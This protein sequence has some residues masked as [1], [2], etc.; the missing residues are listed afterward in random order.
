M[1][2]QIPVYKNIYFI[3]IELA[4]LKEM[5]FQVYLST[6]PIYIKPGTDRNDVCNHKPVGV[7]KLGNPEGCNS[8]EVDT[9]VGRNANH[10][11]SGQWLL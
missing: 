5:G 8:S 10:S 9:S 7:D 11:M 3:F 4:D 2:N 1:L 6:G